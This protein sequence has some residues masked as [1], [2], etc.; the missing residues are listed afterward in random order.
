MKSRLP[1]QVIELLNFPVPPMYKLAIRD[2]LQFKTDQ[3]LPLIPHKVGGDWF[4]CL[5]TCMPLVALL[6]SPC[7]TAEYAYINDLLIGHTQTFDLAMR[8]AFYNCMWYPADSNPRTHLMDW[9]NQIP[10]REPSFTSEPSSYVC[11]RFTLPLIIFDEDFQIETAV[12]QMDIN[13]SNYR[14][15]PHSCF[16]FYLRLLNIIDF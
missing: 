8:T 6:A 5:T 7:S 16:H 11:N 14:A 9:M 3:A 4:Q 12:E 15:N 13:E 1:E 10:E 2:R